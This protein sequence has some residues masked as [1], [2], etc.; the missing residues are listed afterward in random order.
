MQNGVVLPVLQRPKRLAQ[1][2]PKRPFSL[3]TPASPTLLRAIPALK[4]PSSLPNPAQYEYPDQYEAEDAAPLGDD[5][6]LLAHEEPE[7]SGD[8][9]GGGR[10]PGLSGDGRSFA[11]AK[12]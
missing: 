5:S 9:S 12:P 10:V 8:A 6:N 1:L 11:N 3:P 2:R 7:A 4:H